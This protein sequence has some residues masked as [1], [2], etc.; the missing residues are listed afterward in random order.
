MPLRFCFK[1]TFQRAFDNLPAEKQRL[2]LKAL[3]APAHYFQSG[4][5]PYGLRIKKLYA[6]GPQK[7]FE[8]RI[9]I[10]LRL[11]W[12]QTEEET[13][14]ALLGGHDEVQRFLKNL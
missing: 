10:D 9:G 8:A 1:S 13:I 7:T 12:V 6:R 11:V 3:E 2:V 5:A 14:F 4:Q